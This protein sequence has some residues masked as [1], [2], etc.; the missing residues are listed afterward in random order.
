M[1]IF[2]KEEIIVCF[3]SA[4]QA[5]MAEQSLIEEKFSVRIMPK[6]SAIKKGCGFCLRFLPEEFHRAV[7]FLSRLGVIVTEA[8][9]RDESGVYK[10]ISAI[11]G[12][13]NKGKNNAEKL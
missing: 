9:Q 3:E 5:I 12:N 11:N 1:S 10:K 6:P 7:V 13:G 2:S 4:T 8:Y